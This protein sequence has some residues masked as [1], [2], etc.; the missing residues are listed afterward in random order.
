MYSP[1]VRKGGIIAFHDIVPGPEELVGSVP[2]FWEEIKRK[3]K[4]REIVEQYN[5]GGWGIGILEVEKNEQDERDY[6]S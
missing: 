1:L 3:Y 2:R 5:Q 6:L 4:Y